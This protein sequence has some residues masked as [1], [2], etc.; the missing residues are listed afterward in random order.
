MPISDPDST[1]RKLRKDPPVVSTASKAPAEITNLTPDKLNRRKRP[2]VAA[3]AT[4]LIGNTPLVQIS[5]FAKD[6][7]GTVLLKLES[8]TPGF[9]VKDRIAVAMIEEA[10]QRGEITPGKTTLIE[11]TSGNTGIG[12]AWVAAAKGYRLIL[13]MPESMSQERRVLLLGYGAELVLT[14]P[15]EGMAGAVRRAEQ[16]QAETP[17]S[18]IPGQFIN[19]ANPEIHR[20]TTAVEIWEDTNGGVDIVVSGIGTGGT[21]T[22]VGQV[23]KQL[24]PGV[25]IVAVEPAESPLLSS[26]TFGPHKIQ[27]LGANFVP[28][29]LDTTIYDEIVLV[30]SDDAIAASRDL[31]RTEGLLVGISSG[32]AAHAAREVASREENR[33][34][35]IVAVLPD[36][37]ERYLSTLLFQELREKAAGLTAS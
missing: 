20:T 9:S 24:K 33:G 34:K 3:N 18:W 32:A 37:G 21:I 29:V 16:I 11:P 19:S 1:V 30:S 22:G 13:T 7:P 12:L 23:L 28:D 10:E 17:D 25:K 31:M 15:S 27:G 5:R 36:T 8:F 6:T 14:P 2:S 26:G 35:T 4:E